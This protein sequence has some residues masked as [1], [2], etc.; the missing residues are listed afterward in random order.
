VHMRSQAKVSIGDLRMTSSGQ[1]PYVSISDR[2]F[3]DKTPLV[4]EGSACW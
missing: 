3:V 2:E 1:S 4:S